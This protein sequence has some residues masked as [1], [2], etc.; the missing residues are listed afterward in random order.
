MNAAFLS[1]IA[2]FESPYCIRLHTIMKLKT[3]VSI[4]AT[5]AAL[6]AAPMFASPLVIGNQVEVGDA[7]GGVFGPS[8]IASDANGLYSSVS[9]QL[10]G[11]GG[12]NTSAGVFVLDYRSAGEANWNQ[13]LS[14]CLEPDVYLTPFSNPYTVNSVGRAGS[15]LYPEALISELWGRFYVA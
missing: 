5:M 13:F 14:F 3:L 1:G 8:P 4:A 6:S 9:F 7:A 12:V 10:N 2:I 11:S 15:P